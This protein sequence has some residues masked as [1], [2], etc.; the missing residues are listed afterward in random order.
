MSDTTCRH[1]TTYNALQ[2]RELEPMSFGPELQIG[3]TL[4][5]QLF[6][7]A[8]GELELAALRRLNNFRGTRHDVLLAASVCERHGRRALADKFLNL[9]TGEVVS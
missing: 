7:F 9:L 2:G 6:A 1:E 3:D 4:A 8:T 5:R